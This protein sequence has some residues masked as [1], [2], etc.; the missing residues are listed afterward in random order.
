MTI[1]P[2]GPADAADLARIF[3]QAWRHG[4]RGVV[5]DDIIDGL[6]I[7]RWTAEFAVLLADPAMTTSV[8]RDAGEPAG[9]ARFGPDPIRPALGY[10][11]SLYVDPAAAG[12]G[13]GRAL[14][15][16]ALTELAGRGHSVVSLW[17][18]AANARARLLYERAGFR[19]TGEQLT[20]PRWGALE[21]R[22]RAHLDPAGAPPACEPD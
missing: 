15:D 3:V 17:V 18:F 5:A 12:R 16:H 11:A 22:Y 13:I 7:T 20:E 9:F 6:D 14:L 1:R 4:Y 21:L 2:A 19:L 8:W 10:L